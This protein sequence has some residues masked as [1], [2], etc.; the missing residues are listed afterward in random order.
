VLAEL[1]A[2]LGEVIRDSLLDHFGETLRPEQFQDHA[3]LVEAIRERD[4]D[5]AAYES[6]SYMDCAPAEKY[7]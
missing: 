7:E 5:R 6:G 1:H 2:D 3:R 4:S